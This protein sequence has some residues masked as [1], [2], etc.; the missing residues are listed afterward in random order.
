MSRRVIV[1]CGEKRVDIVNFVKLLGES[2]VEQNSEQ[3]SPSSE[4]PLKE[5]LSNRYVHKN[6]VEAS[7]LSLQALIFLTRGFQASV[8]RDSFF[9]HY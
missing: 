4:N 8:W 7:G 2:R 3:P 5:I 9:S 6:Q 1:Q